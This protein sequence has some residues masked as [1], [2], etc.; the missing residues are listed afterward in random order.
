MNK[1][2]N[3]CGIKICG[4][5]EPETAAEIAKLGVQAI[6]L[7]F[8]PKSRRCVTPDQA[9]E[10]SR[11]LPERIQTIGIFV[12]ETADTIAKTAGQSGLTGVQLHGQEPPE[13][14]EKLKNKG[15]MVI[16]A[17][18]TKGSPSIAEAD[19]YAADAYLIECAQGK[20]PGGNAMA[21]NWREANGFGDNHPF[22][23]AGGLN[24]E[25]VASAICNAKP[26]AVDVSSGVEAGPGKKDMA[27]VR[28]FIHAV[29]KYNC[30]Y[31]IRRIFNADGR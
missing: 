23:L 15:L 4:I 13:V 10:I 30:Q 14:V 7:V 11:A 12:N 21:W 8:F 6:G 27:K 9:L 25:N 24:P 22:I 2:D 28:A 31:P 5:T 18:Y 17:L 26:H 1:A 19:Q 29:Q 16:K 20:L 3:I